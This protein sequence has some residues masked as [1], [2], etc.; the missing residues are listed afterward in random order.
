MLDLSEI[1][2]GQ[3]RQ[4]KIRDLCLNLRGSKMSF[5]KDGLTADLVISLVCLP[6]YFLVVITGLCIGLLGLP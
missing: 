1:A 6:F 5:F 4:D 3:H 2:L